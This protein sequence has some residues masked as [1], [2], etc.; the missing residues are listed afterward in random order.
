MILYLD[1]SALVKRYVV[2]QGTTAVTHLIA[3]ADIVGTAVITRAEMAAAFAKA[4][5]VGA[6]LRDEAYMVLQQFRAHWP[7]LVRLQA[8]EALMA[9]ADTL[10]WQLNLRGYDAVHLAA[11]LAWQEEMSQIITLATFDHQLWTAAQDSGLAV[12]PEDWS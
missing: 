3:Q 4:A 6:L 7:A 9:R 2:E 10:A 12:F 11:A 8:S 5:R 1:T